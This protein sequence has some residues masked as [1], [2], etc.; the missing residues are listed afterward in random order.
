MKKQI[1]RI[2]TQLL[3]AIIMV[4]VFALLMIAGF[5]LK[6][7]VGA[8]KETSK[9]LRDIGYLLHEA[10]ELEKIYIKT[11]KDSEETE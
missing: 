4:P 9:W 2:V 6:I 10:W 5:I 8:Y 1:L 11:G 7:M 3:L